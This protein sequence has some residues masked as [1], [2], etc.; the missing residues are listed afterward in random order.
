MDALTHSAPDPRPRLHIVEDDHGVR[1]SMQLLFQGQGFA[2]RAYPSGEALLADRESVPPDCLLVDYRLGDLNGVA[3]L[4]AVRKR[5]WAGPAVLVTGFPSAEL[6]ARALQA[7]YSA[8]FEKPLRE[9]T[10]VQ[11][12][13]RLVDPAAA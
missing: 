12:L 9:R 1:R 3:L 7:G 5:G 2:V 10:L 13:R 4:A 11:A 8:V 6:T